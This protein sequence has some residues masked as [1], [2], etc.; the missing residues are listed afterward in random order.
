MK[1]FPWLSGEGIPTTLYLFRH[2][3]VHEKHRKYLYGQMDVELSPKGIKQSI[4]VGKYLK[5]TPIDHVYSSDLIRAL[6]LGREISRHKDLQPRL[7]PRLR[8]RHFGDWQ[9][10]PW[11]KIAEEYPEEV[12]K[13]LE[14]RHTV[15]APGESESFIDVQSRVLPFVQEVLT[16]HR[17]EKV[18]I[19]AHSGP[20]RIILADALGLPLG[21]IFTFDQ[22]YCAMNIVDY[23]ESGR[24]RVRTLNAVH[25]L[26]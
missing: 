26:K 24:T 3:E 6:T 25:F 10:K 16:K 7:D 2:G 4:R 11:D 15:R 1:G 22:D 14:S 12:E 5:K 23:F 17:G 13:Y 9:G 8:E 21:S 20:V 18:A 19:T